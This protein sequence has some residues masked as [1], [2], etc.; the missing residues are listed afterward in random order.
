MTP[1]TTLSIAQKTDTGPILVAVDLGPH[2]DAAVV[3]G[4]QAAQCLGVGLRLLH[5]VHDPVDRPG[6]YRREQAA[7][8]PLLPAMELAREMATQVLPRLR[9]A[10]HGL[11]ALAAADWL[12][13]SGLPQQRI[14]E[15]SAQLDA[16]M[17]VLGAASGR[18]GPMARLRPSL[19]ARISQRSAV[20]VMVAE[21]V[22][23]ESDQGAAM[24]CEAICA[25]RSIQ[26]VYDSWAA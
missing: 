25:Q 2:S 15:V 7:S 13:V 12:L 4:A 19:A 24:D 1:T 17:L 11:A 26:R 14:L 16:G 10:H 18:L 22:C 21:A 6:F 8:G 3:L 23:S 9:A 20:P 5:V